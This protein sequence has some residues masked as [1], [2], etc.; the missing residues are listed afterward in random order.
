MPPGEVLEEEGAI[1]DK[2]I[3]SGKEYTGLTN[4][5]IGKRFG[6]LSYSG[7]TRVSQRFQEKMARNMTLRRK[8]EEIDDRISNVEG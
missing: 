5:E 4:R 2:A 3:Y 7:V 8:V 1:R 6:D